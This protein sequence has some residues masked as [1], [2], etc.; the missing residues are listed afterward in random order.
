MPG[1]VAVAAGSPAPC[2][3]AGPERFV[4]VPADPGK[5]C[6]SPVRNATVAATIDL[7]G[8]R[9][10]GITRHA[11][12]ASTAAYANGLYDPDEVADLFDAVARE[13]GAPVDL[14]YCF[15]DIRAGHGLPEAAGGPAPVVSGAASRTAMADTVVAPH[16]FTEGETFFLVIDDEEPGWMCLVLNADSRALTPPGGARFPVRRR[17]SW[18]GTPSAPTKRLTMRNACLTLDSLMDDKGVAL[19]M[20]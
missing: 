10:E 9:V 16:E 19:A 11:L 5:E 4:R 20:H 2:R 14:S 15:N 18:A 6:V 8:E 1:I 7:S 13:R 3:M 17:T 12:A